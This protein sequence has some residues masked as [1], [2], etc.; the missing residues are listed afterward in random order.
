MF[1]K[2]LV[3]VDPYPPDHNLISCAVSLKKLGAEEVVLAH[4]IVDAPLGLDKML[5][6]QARP[7]MERQKQMLEK[8]GLPAS[9][10][11]EAGSPAHA[12]NDLA[13]KEDVSVVIIGAQGRGLLESITLAGSPLGNVSAKLLHITRR[14]LLLIPG[15]LPA[16]ESGRGTPNLF[17]QVLHPTDF[18]DTA[19]IAFAYLE[20][21][22]RA[23]QCP[24]IILHVQDQSRPA[25][26]LGHRLKELQNLDGLRMQRLQGWLKGLGAP[27]VRID[28]AQGS[29]GAE[30]V[31]KAKTESCSLILMRTQG[32]SITR[33]ILLGSV[34][35]H[36]ARH[37]ALPVLFI[38]A[39]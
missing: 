17:A 10:V 15:T 30:I 9:I 21:V 22:V 12:L 20:T 34:A 5:I 11:M 19:E 35:H 8:A 7:E 36:V 32:K 27:D 25:P 31:K 4:I 18:S 3:C 37:A 14:P 26:H 1:K 28:L 24:V 13:E 6:A 23:T 33:E 2:I 39:L 29:P 16:M 38:P